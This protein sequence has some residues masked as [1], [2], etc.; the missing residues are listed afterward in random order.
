MMSTL[1]DEQ[2]QKGQS[3]CIVHKRENWTVS[4]NEI[5]MDPEHMAV[6]S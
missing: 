3:L 1:S 4:Q 6:S 5:T 2:H